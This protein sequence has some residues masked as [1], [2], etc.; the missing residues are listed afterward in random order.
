MVDG[1]RHFERNIG[2]R[3]GIAEQ[4]LD[5]LCPGWRYG[6][7]EQTAA[8]EASRDLA[9]QRHS[10]LYL[11]NRHRVY[12]DATVE[13]RVTKTEALPDL[14]AITAF[15]DTTQQPVRCNWNLQ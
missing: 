2:M 11:T 5:P 10:S 7:D 3:D 8:G 4:S 12:P 6:R 13:L 15:G 1:D 9:N 14:A